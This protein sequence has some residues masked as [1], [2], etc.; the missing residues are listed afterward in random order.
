MSQDDTRGTDAAP[1]TTYQPDTRPILHVCLTCRQR[2][3]EG[4]IIETEGPRAGTRLHDN[5]A[6]A[7]PDDAPFVVRGVECLSNCKRACTVGLTSPM[8]WSYVYGDLDPVGSIDD[9]IAGA[10]LYAGTDDGIVPWRE[11]PQIF[12]KGVIA[13]IPPFPLSSSHSA[14]PAA[15]PARASEDQS[16]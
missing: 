11:R 16:A 9:I 8:R 10:T 2:D 15:N 13:R 4:Q 1:E 5:L 3:A 12:R 14:A 7:L 6:A